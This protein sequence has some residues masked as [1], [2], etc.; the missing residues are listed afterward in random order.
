MPGSARR[1]C[2]LGTSHGVGR[3]ERLAI[4]KSTFLTTFIL[5]RLS[6]IAPQRCLLFLES[7]LLKLHPEIL[8]K[9]GKKQFAVLHYE[10]FVALQERLADADDLIEMRKAKRAESKK[11]AMPLAEV[12]RRLKL[13]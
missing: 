2:S 1:A 4:A 8:V 13:R 7:L 5:R 3:S 11:K 10:E 12:K 9:D 6:N